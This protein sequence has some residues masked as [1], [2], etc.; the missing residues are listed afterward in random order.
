MSRAWK[1]A[2]V[3][4]L[5]IGAVTTSEPSAA[6]HRRG[7]GSNQGRVAAIIQ[8]MDLD[9]NGRVS[10]EEFMQYMSSEFDRIDRDRSGELTSEEISRSSLLMGGGIHTSPGR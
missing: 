9:H 1:I 3:S 7:G 4:A 6:R 10:K 8:R 5:A 2:L